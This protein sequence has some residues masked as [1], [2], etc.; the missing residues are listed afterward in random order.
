MNENMTP[1]G[2]PKLRLLFLDNSKTTRAAMS[3]MLTQ[4]GYEVVAVGTGLEAIEKIKTEPFDVAIM[5]LYMPFM[6]G[7]EAAKII[8]ALPDKC[9]DIP[10]IALTASSDP[11]DMDICKNASMNDFVIKS[12][13]NKGLFE[14]LQRYCQTLGKTKTAK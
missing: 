1:S 2:P 10:I 8:R 7:Y 5:D 3:M 12:E 13:D 6:N 4:Q 14:I 9:K 11:R